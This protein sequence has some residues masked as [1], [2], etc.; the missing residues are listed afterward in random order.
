MLWELYQVYTCFLSLR[1]SH[2]GRIHQ[3]CINWHLPLHGLSY[4]HF[5]FKNCLWSQKLQLSECLLRI[6]VPT[7]Q[8]AGLS[9]IKIWFRFCFLIC[10]GE[11]SDAEGVMGTF[12]GWVI[13]YWR[14]II[15]CVLTSRSSR[16]HCLSHSSWKFHWFPTPMLALLTTTLGG[17]LQNT[18]SPGLL[19][20][21]KMVAIQGSEKSIHS[22]PIQP[23]ISWVPATLLAL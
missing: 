1:N 5:L 20:E 22:F 12:G 16:L 8:S 11:S 6:K 4:P 3:E 19:S 9:F 23:P 21:S 2:Y 13:R 15:Q 17:L 14:T 18:L 10:V 7:R